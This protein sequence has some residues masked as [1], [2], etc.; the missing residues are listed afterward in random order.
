MMAYMTQRELS[1]AGVS[2]RKAL[3]RLDRMGQLLAR[4]A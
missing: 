3:A 1:E 2:D 4:Y